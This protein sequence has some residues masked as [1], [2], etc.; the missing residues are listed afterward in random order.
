MQVREVALVVG[1][2]QASLGQRLRE[3]RALLE[4]EH[5]R[6]DVLGGERDRALDVAPLLAE[7]LTRRREDQVERHAL[8]AALAQH[9][10]AANGVGGVVDTAEDLQPAI[11]ERLDAETHAIDAVAHERADL[12]RA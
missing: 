7:R 4:G 6:A 10:H 1:R 12:S 11:V 5:V 9:G 8:D 2:G 3:R